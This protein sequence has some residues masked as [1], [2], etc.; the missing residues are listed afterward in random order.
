M[1]PK[2]VLIEILI[3]EEGRRVS[4]MK[5]EEEI[6]EEAFIPWCERIEKVMVFHVGRSRDV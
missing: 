5:I 4:D 3:V 2:R 1:V 6:R